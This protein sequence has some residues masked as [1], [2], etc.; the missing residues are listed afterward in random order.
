[1]SICHSIIRKHG[2]NVTVDSALR[3]GTTI[4]IYLPSANRKSSSHRNA[5][6][7]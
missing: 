1:M 4:H 7:M 2:G 3:R 5:D 6:T